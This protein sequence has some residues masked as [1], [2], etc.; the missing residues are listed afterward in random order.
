MKGWTGLFYKQ[1]ATTITKTQNSGENIQ[2][3]NIK[4]LTNCFGQL[5]VDAQSK[6]CIADE[7]DYDCQVL[8]FSVFLS[9]EIRFKDFSLPS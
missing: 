9:R 8:T 7:L 4:F 5:H 1:I 3:H 6:V 2:F